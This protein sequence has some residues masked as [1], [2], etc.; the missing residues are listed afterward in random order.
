MS[1]AGIAI[2]L[3]P[4]GCT[5]TDLDD[6]QGGEGGASSASVSASNSATSGASS[7]TGGVATGYASVVLGDTPIAYWRLGEQ[8]GTEARDEVSARHGK[9]LGNVTL[10]ADGATDGNTAARFDGLTSYVSV[11]NFPGFGGTLPFS[12]EAWIEPDLLTA[13][14]AIVGHSY[15]DN[16][17]GITDGYRVYHAEGSLYCQRSS[18][19]AIEGLGWADALPLGT[20]THFVLVY[21]GLTMTLFLNGESVTSAASRTPIGTNGTFG[22]GADLQHESGPVAYFSGSID[23]VAVYDYALDE[24]QV[25]AHYAAR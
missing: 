7:G 17:A 1:R 14:R 22:F 18:F 13:V 9:Y 8:D 3:L 16:A 15:Y 23:E 5:L 20:Y 24:A 2:L 10:G 4:L 6:L 11:P 12:V 19:S 25:A 21:D